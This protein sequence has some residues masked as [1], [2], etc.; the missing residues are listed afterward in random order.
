MV[1]VE[2]EPNVALQLKAVRTDLRAQNKA[3]SYFIASP[4]ADSRVFRAVALE[5]HRQCTVFR[6]ILELGR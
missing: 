3:R 1:S 5:F 6:T 2:R 4:K